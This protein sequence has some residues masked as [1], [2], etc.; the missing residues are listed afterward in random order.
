[1]LCVNFVQTENPYKK[2]YKSKTSTRR[3]RDKVLVSVLLTML[4]AICICQPACCMLDVNWL[5]VLV[6]NLPS[7]CWLHQHFMS[8]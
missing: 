8:C 5:F 7:F 4:M 2:V 3:W 6:I 1:M